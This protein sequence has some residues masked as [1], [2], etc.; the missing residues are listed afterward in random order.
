MSK[1]QDSFKENA[2]NEEK[3][4]ERV[5]AGVFEKQSEASGVFESLPDVFE[6]QSN[7]QEAHPKV[8]EIRSS[9]AKPKAKA[10]SPRVWAYL[11]AAAAVLLVVG[12]G[13]LVM[14][15]QNDSMIRE[16]ATQYAT[17]ESI[18]HNMAF[19]M[20]SVDINPSFEVYVDAN[21]NVLSIE[22]VNDDA[23]TMD[24]SMFL[25]M[26]AQEA[27]AGIINSSEAAG[28]IH[29][30]DE[31]ED[32]V[33][34]TTVLLEDESTENQ[35]KQDHLGQLIRERVEAAGELGDTTKVAIIKA[36]K[37]EL[38]EAREKDIPMGLYIINGM[39]EN[40]GEMIPVSEFVSNKDNLNK[41]KNR[42]DV[43]EKK[44]KS[45]GE[46]TDPTTGS[47]ESNQGSNN[48]NANPNAT[49]PNETA[50]GADATKPNETAPGADDTKPNETAPGVVDGTKPNETAPGVV[51]GT[52]PNETAPGADATKPNVTAPSAEGT[53]PNETTANQNSTKQSNNGG[54]KN[55]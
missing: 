17:S 4:L 47:S 38:F 52:K 1:L 15:N 44:N 43:A 33:L 51:D 19:A 37:V 49:K 21:G 3:I 9:E 28:F 41:L 6:I 26:P 25:G 20:I 8:Y 12:I 55:G 23:A 54:S 11:V 14:K 18:A 29:G 34:V 53:K 30:E 13:A 27:V 22:A 24:V 16:R 2:L 48:T 5:S 31:L 32:Y 40:N 36:T 46:K 35:Q 50:P 10:L 39:I 7:V 45:N 42:S